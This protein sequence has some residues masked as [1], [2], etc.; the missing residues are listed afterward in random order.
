MIHLAPRHRA[1]GGAARARGRWPARCRTCRSAC[2]WRW[3]TPASA[4]SGGRRACER[5]TAACSS[6]RTTAC[7]CRPPRPAAA[8]SWRSRSPTARYM[9]DPVSRTFHGRDVFAPV[10]G[11][12]AGGLDPLRARARRSTRRRWCGAQLLGF[13]RDGHRARRR[14]PAH[15]PV[16]Q[17][18]AVRRPAELAELF[19]AGRRG[20]GGG[21]VDDRYLAVCADTFADVERGELVLFEDS[22]RRLS[23]AINRGDAAELLDLRRASGVRIEFA[24]TIDA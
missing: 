19:R 8:S 7:W 10:A 11:H 2:T 18:P 1:A 24:P 14:R 15:R 4:R 6:A 16:R 20:R 17:H 12:L 21:R 3:S 13:E 5:P 9:L 22:E 23:I